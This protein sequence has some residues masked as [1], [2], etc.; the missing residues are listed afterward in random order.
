MINISNYKYFISIILF[1]LLSA[2]AIY[3]ARAMLAGP[4]I[5]ITNIHDG[6]VMDSPLLTIE[7]VAKNIAWI[8]LNGRQIFT[9]ENGI[10]SEK[11][12]VSP[13]LSIMTL[14][15]RDRFGHEP[16]TFV[17]LY[18]HDSYSSHRYFHTRTRARFYVREH[19]V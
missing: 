18:V 16:T 4:E 5:I 8:N 10:W 19:G 2:Y 6:Q 14:K 17:I 9:D 12:I 11:L 3:Q 13:G 7:G 1:I 15:A